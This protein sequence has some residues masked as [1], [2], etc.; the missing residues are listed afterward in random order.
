MGGNSDMGRRKSEERVGEE[1]KITF[2]ERK[3]TRRREIRAEGRV[4][5]GNGS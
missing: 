1:R 2:A 3:E 5:G 4:R